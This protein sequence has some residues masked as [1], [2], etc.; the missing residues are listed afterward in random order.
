MALQFVSNS[1]NLIDYASL[2]TLVV[3]DIPGMRSALKMTLANF[4]I[5]RTDVA[6][7]AQETIY[8]L[9]NGS[10]DLI[11]ADYNLGDGRDGQQLLEE[12]RHRGLIGLQTIYIM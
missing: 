6:A 11:L 9:N 1:E 12:L 4:G 5:T 10:Y 3:D 7:T 8:R 2:R